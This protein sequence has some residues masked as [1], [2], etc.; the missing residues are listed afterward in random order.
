MPG[1]DEAFDTT[2]C[3]YGDPTQPPDIAKAQEL[4]K[5]AGAEGTKVTVWGNNDDPTDKVT[6]AYADML[7]EIGFDAEPKIIDGGVYFQT[8]GNEKTD[9]S[10]GLRQLVPGF[11]TPAELLFPRRPGLD[12]A[13]E[14]PE[15]RQR[16][17]S[18]GRRRDRSLSLETDTERWPGTG[19]LWTSTSISPP[20]S[21]I[22]PYG[23][24]KLATFLSERMDFDSAMFHPVYFNDYSTWSLKEGE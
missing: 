24:R 9:G 23:H 7:N 1:Y 16:G 15:L 10:D 13:D 5:Q 18:G 11:P 12:P 17:R 4:L 22:A 19:P 2:E 20:Q 8:I 3:P 14:Q 6:E 21:Y